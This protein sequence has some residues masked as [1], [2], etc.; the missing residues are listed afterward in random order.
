M[1]QEEDVRQ[2][3]VWL[4][5]RGHS[6]DEVE[7]IMRRLDRYDAEM[8]RQSIFDSIDTGGFDIEAVI[9][10]ALGDTGEQ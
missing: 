6:P 5:E 4:T 2:V 7:R 10:E 1:T 8:I 3:R 9:N